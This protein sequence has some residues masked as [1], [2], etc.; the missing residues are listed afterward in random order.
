LAK[1]RL[2]GKNATEGVAL[3]LPAS[4]IVCGELAALSVIVTEP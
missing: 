2:L 1:V 4:R 3:P